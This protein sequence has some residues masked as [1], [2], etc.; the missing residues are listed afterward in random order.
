PTGLVLAG[1]A[2]GLALGT[3]ATAA[4]ALPALAI[5][6]LLLVGRRIE[7]PLIAGALLGGVAAILLGGYAYVQNWYLYGSLSGS[8]AVSREIGTLLDRIHW[9]GFVANVARLVYTFAFADLSGPLADPLLRPLAVPLAQGL[10][11]GGAWLF[12]ALDIPTELE[13]FDIELWPEFTFALDPRVHDYSSGVGLVGG[14]I[15]IVA[16]AMLVWPRRVSCTRRL[17]A[18]ATLSYVAALSA[19]LSW[20][21]FGGGRYLLTAGALGAPLLGAVVG[22][23]RTGARTA[24]ALVLVVWSGATGLYVACFG[25]HKPLPLVL[26]S[27]RQDLM[28]LKVGA[29]A[30]LFRELDQRLEPDA[31]VGVYGYPRA[32]GLSN[33]VE[34]PLFGERFTRTLVPLVDAGYAERVG[35]R[36]PLAWTND[37]LLAAYRPRYVLVQSPRPA[38]EAIPFLADRCVAVQLEYGKPRTLWE[39]WRC[40]DLPDYSP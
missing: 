25:E 17:L 16:T 33:H 39:L 22:D 14:A 36:R 9:E 29:L 38:I 15:L 2:A 40:L 19:T 4:F 31:V 13:G 37:R 20:S 6:G 24:L 27:S 34:Y 7:P 18:L 30:P 5:A 12:G 11:A 32:H 28:L 8:S 35:L 3:K 21:P 23:R 26:K 10:A 1:A